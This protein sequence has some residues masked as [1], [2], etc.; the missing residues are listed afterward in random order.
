MAKE[1]P[2][3]IHLR[4]NKSGRRIWASFCPFSY[5]K[6][7]LQF[8]NILARGNKSTAANL[9]LFFLIFV[10]QVKSYIFP[11]YMRVEINQRRQNSGLK[12]V[13]F[14]VLW[15]PCSALRLNSKILNFPNNN[16]GH[17]TS[18]YVHT[19][20]CMYNCGK[21]RQI[22][23]LVFSFSKYVTF[24]KFLSKKYDSDFPMIVSNFFE[25]PRFS[26]FSFH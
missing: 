8:S 1:I 24:T 25:C 14:L 18:M 4:E 3:H 19:Y 5:A 22:K 26:F 13:T 10:R 16:F 11:I 9:G 21:I 6:Q 12:P 17:L 7:K 15:L 2:F 23:S 20:I